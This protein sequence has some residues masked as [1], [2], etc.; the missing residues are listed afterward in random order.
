MEQGQNHVHSFENIVIPATCRERGYVLHRCTC[1]Y[2]HKDQF[3]P[4]GKH[5]FAL[6]AENA[7]NCENGGSREYTCSVC[8]ETKTEPLS[9][10]GHNWSGWNVQ[11]FASCA[12]EGL[13]VRQCRRCGTSQ[14]QEIPATGHKRSKGQKNAAGQVEY[15]CLNCGAPME[16]PEEKKISPKKKK[17]IICIAIAIL[18]VSLGTAAVWHSLA[19]RPSQKKTAEDYYSAA[20]RLIQ[21]GNYTDAY[22]NLLKCQKYKDSKELLEGFTV[23]YQSTSHLLTYYDVAGNVEKI[24]KSTDRRTYDK[25]GNPTS[26]VKYDENGALLSE[27]TWDN[28]Y[29][30][31]NHLIKQTKYGADGNPEFLYT[32]SYS[33]NGNLTEEIRYD[34]KENKTYEVRYDDGGTKIYEVTYYPVIYANAI[35]TDS[36]GNKTEILLAVEG[37]SMQDAYTC[38]RSE[39]GYIGE[40]VQYDKNGNITDRN[41]YR[42]DNSGNLLEEIRYDNNNEITGRHAYSYDNS[43][44]LLEE[45]RYD[46]NDEITGRY[47]YSYDN[48]GNLLEEIHYGRSNK[49][50]KS[51]TYSYDNNGNRI[52]R[53]VYDGNGVQTWKEVYEYDSEGNE[54]FSTDYD[55]SG[56]A[57]RSPTAEYTYDAYGVVLKSG[58]YSYYGKITNEEERSADYKTLKETVYRYHFNDNGE[59]IDSIRSEET[60]IYTDPVVFYQP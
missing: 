10:L 57:T 43:G 27:L 32:Y 6:T 23:Q 44:N 11:Q 24:T 3:T 60:Y 8:G 7:P 13:Q 22:Y 30:D 37:G 52:M 50:A 16:K 58:I 26:V 2:E 19:N 39:N 15:Y 41:A 5:A 14:K 38:T 51:R 29:D 31:D 33:R 56:T 12:A 46:N 53:V 54:I 59:Y 21:Q 4:L 18:L 35:Q 55:E 25:N 20:Q 28:I 45:I 48:S 47:T 9:A 1:G 42:Y 34:G 17:T 40:K 49:I 36:K